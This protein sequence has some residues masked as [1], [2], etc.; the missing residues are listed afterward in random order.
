MNKI[1]NDSPKMSFSQMFPVGKLS[2]DPFGL[3]NVKI[4][5]VEITK[6]KGSI[7][8][9]RKSSMKKSIFF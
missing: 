5:P 3:L 6:D 8:S 2:L 7:F 4:S 1:K 9:N